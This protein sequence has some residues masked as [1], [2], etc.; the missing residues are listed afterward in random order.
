MCSHPCTSII[1]VP[2]ITDENFIYCTTFLPS[3][4]KALKGVVHHCNKTHYNK[5]LPLESLKMK[6]RWGKSRQD[7]KTKCKRR[8]WAVFYISGATFF[9]FPAFFLNLSLSPHFLKSFVDE[10]DLSH[11]ILGAIIWSC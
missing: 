3:F 6:T 1:Y 5:I 2:L 10:D 9:F 4:T 8:E 11:F 7:G